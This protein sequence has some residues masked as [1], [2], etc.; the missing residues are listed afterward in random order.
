MEIHRVNV[1]TSYYLNNIYFLDYL[2]IF[3]DP[4]IGCFTNQEH[5]NWLWTS[6]DF[7]V[8][9]YSEKN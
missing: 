4:E 7:D 1:R 3:K 5:W 8:H 2:I 9:Y 6:S